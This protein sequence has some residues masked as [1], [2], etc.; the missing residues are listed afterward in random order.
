MA[1]ILNGETKE[2]YL[3]LTTEIRR[4]IDKEI[5]SITKQV[6]NNIDKMVLDVANYAESFAEMEEVQL[7][8][9][10]NELKNTGSGL[11]GNI[12]D[13]MK[14]AV[15]DKTFTISE[16]VFFSG[17]KEQ[18]DYEK[19]DDLL[20]WQAMLV[21]TCPDCLPLHGQV[22]TRAGWVAS[23]GVPNMRPTVCTIHGKCHCILLPE[24]IMPV[25]TD[26]REPIRIQAEKIR[27][28]ELKR[29]KNYAQSTQTALLGQI[30]NPKS[31]VFDLRKVKK[32]T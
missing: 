18:A 9:Q 2:A 16:D 19:D 1:L 12:I 14:K 30:N 21:N 23:G 32:I 20:M 27:K 26:M 8:N 5:V 22:D 17:L 10:L 6:E 13:E 3:S 28:A 31:K 4:A 29:G 25:N 7:I 11:F 24:N 15:T